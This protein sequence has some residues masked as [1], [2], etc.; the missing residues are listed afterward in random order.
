LENNEITVE[1][2]PDVFTKTK[3]SDVMSRILSEGNKATELSLIGLFRAHRITGWRRRQPIFGKP[4]FVFPKRR[5]AVFVDGCFWHFCPKHGKFPKSNKS[6]WR[7]KLLA[8]KRRDK[9][10]TRTLQKAGWKVVRVWECS[11]SNYKKNQTRFS[12]EQFLE[13]IA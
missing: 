7:R 13:L 1:L 9:L 11:L 4:D 3:R 5:M 10:V 12:S 2:M 8:N 6:Y